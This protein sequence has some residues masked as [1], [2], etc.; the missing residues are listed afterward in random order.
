MEKGEGEEAKVDA[1]LDNVFTTP[2]SS[3]WSDMKPKYVC[4]S[5]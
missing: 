4:M 3:G 2:V 5:V 1:V